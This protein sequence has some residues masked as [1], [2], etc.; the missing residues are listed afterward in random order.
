MRE[1]TS[2]AELSFATSMKLREISD[3]AAAKLLDEMTE[4]TFPRSKLILTHCS[5]VVALLISARNKARL[6][7]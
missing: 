6:F 7:S 4:I 3:P 5:D 1:D 2:I